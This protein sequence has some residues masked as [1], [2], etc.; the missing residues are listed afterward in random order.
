MTK[1]KDFRAKVH[2]DIKKKYLI[3][4]HYMELENPPDIVWTRMYQTKK[5]KE[6]KA[7]VTAANT[8][9]IVETVQSAIDSN[10]EKAITN[11]KKKKEIALPLAV[12]SE[13]DPDDFDDEAEEEDD[14]A[15]DDEERVLKWKRKY[16]ELLGKDFPALSTTG[17]FLKYDSFTATLSVVDNEEYLQEVSPE[18]LRMASNVLLFDE[19]PFA[20]SNDL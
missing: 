6:K 17:I 1:L 10:L 14:E 5:A 7:A 11:R 18:I 9:A 8:Q 12:A 16:I 19:L 15:E 13:A 4:L 3:I 20:P 2:E